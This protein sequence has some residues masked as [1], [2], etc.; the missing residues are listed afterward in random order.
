[1]TNRLQEFWNDN[2]LEDFQSSKASN[3][4]CSGEM[5]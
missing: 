3:P 2:R 4:Y 5:K 1:L